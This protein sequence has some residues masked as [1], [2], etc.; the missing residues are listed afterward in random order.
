VQSALPGAPVDLRRPEKGGERAPTPPPADSGRGQPVTAREVLAVCVGACLLSVGMNWPIA[1]HLGSHIGEDL[2][3]PVRT[4]WQLAWQGHAI[5][6]HPLHLW[7]ANAFWPHR[8]TFAF[9]D[10]L[11]GYLPASLIG[12]GPVAALVRYNLLFLFAYALCFVGAYLL[13]RELGVGRGAA[14]VAGAAFAYAPFR[15]SMNGHLHVISSGGIPLVLFLLVR[16]YR[17]GS[18]RTVLAG[19]LVAAWQLTLGFTLGLQLG[20]LLLVLGVIAAV[21]W[22]RRGRPRLPRPLVVSTGAGILAVAAA[23]AFQ[24]RPILQVAGDY[25]NAHRAGGEIAHYSAP[26]KAF[27]S[28]PPEDRLW[29]SATAS[30]RHTLN[31]PNEQNQFPG[32]AVLLLAIVG[33][34]AGTVFSWR[35]RAG[36]GVAV[37]VLAVTALGYGI[38][39]GDLTYRL[40]HHAPGWAG[41]RTPGRL[42]TLTSLGLGL[43]AAAGVHRLGG[44]V[45]GMLR[46]R[47]PRLTFAAPAL[48]ACLAAAAILAEGLGTVPNPKVP[49][50][51]AGLDAVAAPQL[52][53]PTNPAFDRVYQYWST[54]RFQ[55]IVNGVATFSFTSQNKLRQAMNSFPD[56]HSVELLQRM[57]VRTVILHLNIHRFPIPLKWLAPH[58]RYARLAAARSVAGLPLTETRRG[59]YV[60]YTLKP[61]AGA[62]S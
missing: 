13:A 2:G 11:L 7:N 57:G 53:L 33:V 15:L 46:K 31:T 10:S 12:H 20:Y 37:L 22:L 60:V 40:L 43:L 17:R 1:A 39:D 14:V 45:T 59:S 26:P 6:H 3:D 35:L 19:W 41:V 30:V 28:A 44:E 16:G 51:P 49:P 29:G 23:V 32:I 9:S 48:V 5:L 18:R 24:A 25:P 4:A 36:I 21:V 56:V 50:V 61:L 62:G 58:P 42:A 47:R 54:D 55:P 8:E 38:L 52:H 27:L 34:G